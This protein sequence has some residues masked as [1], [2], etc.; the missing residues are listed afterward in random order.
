MTVLE[1]VMSLLAAEAMDE[2]KVGLAGGTLTAAALVT[3]VA[4][5][6]LS[7][8][9]ADPLGC[10]AEVL[11][12]SWLSMAGLC[13][14]RGATSITTWYWLSALYIVETERCP[15]ASYKVLSI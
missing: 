11:I 9:M 5:P 8:V 10:P 1:I 6:A 7:C 2:D 15:N 12:H 13:K 4:D 3:P 14:K